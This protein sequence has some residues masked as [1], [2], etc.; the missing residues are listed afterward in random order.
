MEIYFKSLGQYH[1][2]KLRKFQGVLESMKHK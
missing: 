2:I 1:Q